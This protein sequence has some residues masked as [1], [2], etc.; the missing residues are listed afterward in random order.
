MALALAAA[1]ALAAAV[2]QATAASMRAVKC[3]GYVDGK[4]KGFG[5]MNSW[6]HSVPMPTP[7]RGK[8]L[9]RVN[10]SSPNPEDVDQITSRL[11]ADALHLMDK[12]LG[13]DVAGVVTAVGEGT[14][15][16]IKVGDEVWADLDQ[17]GLFQG[18]VELGAW[19]EYAVAEERQVG[20]KPKTLSMREAGVMPL[21]TM[22]SYK[23][24]GLAGAPWPAGS[25]K[26]VL[27]T[28]GQGGTGH[29]AVQLAR[30]MGAA[31]I[32]SVADTEHLDFVRSLGADEV[33]DFKKQNVWDV[34]ANNSIDVVYDNIGLPGNADRAMPKLR[35]GG[36][37]I[38]IAGKPTA[39]PRSDVTQQHFLLTDSRYPTLDALA[40]MVDAGKLRPRVQQ[41]V[42]L[43]RIGDALDALGKGVVGK[44]AIDATA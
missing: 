25:N 2:P 42:P 23:S 36:F 32:I 13:F 4:E 17:L 1:A 15:G 6:V 39:H 26:T 34:V 7:G 30:A 35:S 21:V 20:L 19:A 37:F 10:T 18:I 3:G 24:L 14:D 9:I 27:I 40:Q 31:R 5:A 11:Q 38:Y 16:R 28:S 22:T 29:V 44:V 12:T 43:S 8:V 41:V 33:V